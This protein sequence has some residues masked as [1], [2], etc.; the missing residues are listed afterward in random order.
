MSS[1][2]SK[3]FSRIS[4][5]NKISA[6]NKYAEIIERITTESL[7]TWFSGHHHLDGDCNWDDIADTYG[8]EDQTAFADSD[9]AK[10]AIQSMIE[11]CLSIRLGINEGLDFQVYRDSDT[12]GDEVHDLILID[13]L[14]DQDFDLKTI[15]TYRVVEDSREGI[16]ADWYLNY[17]SNDG[18]LKFQFA[19]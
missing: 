15:Q 6:E 2:F 5:P 14:Q 1:T 12:Y 8:N 9:G 11:E 16:S 17:L 18:E 10:G 13:L 19:E 7:K 3:T 4:I